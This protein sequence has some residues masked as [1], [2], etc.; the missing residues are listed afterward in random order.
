[1]PTRVL[2]AEEASV[3]RLL[4]P[5][6]QIFPQ[7]RASGLD[8]RLDAMDHAFVADA[9]FAPALSMIRKIKQHR[10]STVHGVSEKRFYGFGLLKLLR[11]AKKF[12]CL[13]IRPDE[14]ERVSPPSGVAHSRR[15]N[16][17]I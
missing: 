7:R 13:L 16:E 2:S 11:Q 8:R 17:N 15:R 3:T 1:V 4:Q 5:Q 14:V 12:C 10:H 6:F 9:V